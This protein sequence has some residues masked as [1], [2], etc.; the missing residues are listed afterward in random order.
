MRLFS[1]ILFSITTN[2]Y[3]QREVIGFPF[4]LGNYTESYA[5]FN[6]A[7]LTTD[8]HADV[9]LGNQRFTGAW[10]N[11]QALYALGAIRLGKQK[12]LSKLRFHAV[13]VAFYT[14]QEGDFL[15]RNRFYGQY[16]VGVAISPEIQLAVGTTIGGMN[17]LVLANAVSAG[18]ADTQLD[19]VLGIRLQTPYIE[20]GYAIS[21]IFN[22]SVQPLAEIYRLVPIYHYTATTQYKINEQI[23]GKPYAYLRYINPQ[24]YD[25]IPS[26]IFILSDLISLGIGYRYRQNLFFSVGLEDIKTNWGKFKVLFSYQNPIGNTNFANF[27]TLELTLVYKSLPQQKDQKLRIIET[28]D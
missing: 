14:E 28:D 15:R 3:A 27:N 23:K 10:N 21:Q 17:Y 20:I 22:R 24:L 25:L 18:G 1:I 13:G 6:P 9:R 26:H 7:Y 4:F 12:E 11:I 8:N 19:G 16:A 5:L 2:L